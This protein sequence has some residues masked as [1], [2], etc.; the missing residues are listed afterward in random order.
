MRAKFLHGIE[1]LDFKG[2][3]VI[4]SKTCVILGFDERGGGYVMYMKPMP[5]LKVK[6]VGG[7][8]FSGDIY[9]DLES[10]WVKKITATVIDMTKTTMFGI[11]V[12]I[13]IP[14]TSLTI[15]FV[16]KEEVE[17]TKQ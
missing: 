2:L 14:I 15:R 16:G 4:N 10:L 13:S 7:T 3:S 5:I 9:I 11:P 8:R 6:T 12:E 17:S 1:T